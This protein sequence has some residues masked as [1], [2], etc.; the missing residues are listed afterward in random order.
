MGGSFPVRQPGTDYGAGNQANGLTLIDHILSANPH[1]NQAAA[2]GSG[3][4]GELEDR[5]N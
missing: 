4:A 5:Y 3:S 2:G 1:P